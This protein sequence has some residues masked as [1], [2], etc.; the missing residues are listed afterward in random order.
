M[1][2]ES[3]VRLQRPPGLNREDSFSDFHPQ[4][5]SMKQ[6][7]KR[8]LSAMQVICPPIGG[9]ICTVPST[10][11]VT[12]VTQTWTC[13]R[14]EEVTNSNPRQKVTR[15]PE[16]RMKGVGFGEGT[17][18]SRLGDRQDGFQKRLHGTWARNPGALCIGQALTCQVRAVSAVCGPCVLGD[19]QLPGITM[20][21]HL[22]FQRCTCLCAYFYLPGAHSSVTNWL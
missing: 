21:S 13:P 18:T 17:L 10:E 4:L 20:P 16:G 3:W 15:A 1:P 12:E 8:N 7:F 14:E 19:P 11:G 6:I 22:H 9:H 2:A 5:K